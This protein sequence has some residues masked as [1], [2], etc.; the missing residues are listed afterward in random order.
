MNNNPTHHPAVNQILSR[1]SSHVE[2]ILGDQLVGIYLHGSLAN[3]G[4]DEYSDIDVIFVVRNEI[5]EVHELKA[6]HTELAKTDSPW[7]VQVEAAYI[8]VDALRQSTPVNVRY[9][10]LDRGRGELL[11]WMDAESD[12]NIYRYL[13]RER[14]IVLSGPEPRTFID[15]VTPEDLR[16]AVA[17]GVS[18][19]FTPLLE[20]SAEMKR[21]GLQSFYVLSICRMM[22]TLKE[23]EILPKQAAAEW[24]QEHLDR[25]W[26]PL[27][28]RALIGRR[29]P[30]R[31]SDPGDIR[32][33]QEMMRFILS[34]V[35]PTI[36]PDVNDVLNRL[37][38]NVKQILGDQFVGMYL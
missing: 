30:N 16:R 35:K 3:G 23:G 2:Q 7:A 26:R 38:V 28:Q 32:E 22:Y 36:Y 33:T 19:W 21:R 24:A 31:D 6:M 13:L 5:S 18:R 14:G 20:D 8:P 29:E 11:H 25:R 27:I 17:G 9:P 12:W 15:P 37:H 10:H 1:L 34:Q 4:F